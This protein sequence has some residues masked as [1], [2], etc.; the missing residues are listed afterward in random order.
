MPHCANLK[1]PKTTWQISIFP[2]DSSFIGLIYSRAALLSIHSGRISKAFN[3]VKL[4]LLF[5]CLEDSCSV[6]VHRSLTHVVLFSVWGRLILFHKGSFPQQ[7]IRSNTKTTRFAKRSTAKVTATVTEEVQCSSLLMR[8]NEGNLGG[9][10][11]DS[12]EEGEMSFQPWLELW[13][14]WLLL[15]SGCNYGQAEGS[16]RVGLAEGDVHSCGP[17]NIGAAVPV[18][19]E[20]RQHVSPVLFTLWGKPKP[21]LLQR[22]HLPPTRSAATG[23]PSQDRSPF[24][25]TS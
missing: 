7:Q 4:C 12:E 15:Q 14:D 10:G 6:F 20:A 9:G 16:Q 11:Y 22:S 2:C 17:A 19:P 24:L 13:C 21:P 8:G 25:P 1:V 23:L 18:R 5:V 3:T